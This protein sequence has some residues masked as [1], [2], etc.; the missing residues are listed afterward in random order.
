M[1]KHVSVRYFYFDIQRT[2]DFAKYQKLCEE[3]RELHG[4]KRPVH[5][6]SDQRQRFDHKLETT[7][8]KIEGTDDTGTV[9]HGKKEDIYLWAEWFT[10]NKNIR[11]GYY[12]ENMQ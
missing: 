6:I 7:T 11:K 1:A 9:L 12:V 10:L 5:F 4:L 3:I 2:A 8:H